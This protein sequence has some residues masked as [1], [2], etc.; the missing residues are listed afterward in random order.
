MAYIIAGLGN[1]GE[2]YETTRHNAG[3]IV[4]KAIASE[5]TSSDF[6]MNKKLSSLTADAKLGKEDILLMMPETFMNK[7]GNALKTLITNPKKAEKLIVV[8]DDFHLPLG[9]IK[10]SFNRSSGGH[11]GLE[12]IIK[13]IKT[14]GFVRIRIGVAPS[15]AAGKTKVISGDKVEKFI[16][17]EFKKEELAVLKKISK[18]A[19]E[20]VVLTI[21]EGRER[22]MGAINSSN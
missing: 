3:R 22:A 10:V 14:E 11:N 19:I 15:S 12:S 16:L 8:Y 21:K 4:L 6:E 1:P 13:A 18:K 9:T 5:L 2:E 20:A 7:S 17:G